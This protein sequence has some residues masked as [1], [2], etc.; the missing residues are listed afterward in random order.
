[1][2]TTCEEKEHDKTAKYA[3]KTTVKNSYGNS[4]IK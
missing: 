1:M 4:A 2:F 3:V